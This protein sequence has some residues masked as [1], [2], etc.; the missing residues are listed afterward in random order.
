MGCLESAFNSKASPNRYERKFLNWERKYYYKNSLDTERGFLS[1]Y[2][3]ARL[4]KNETK[5]SNSNLTLHTGT[6]DLPFL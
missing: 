2:L 1:R 4:A 3:N 6:L 5:I